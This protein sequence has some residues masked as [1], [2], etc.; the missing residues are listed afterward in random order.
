MV[1]SRPGSPEFGSRPQT[2]RRLRAVRRLCIFA[3]PLLAA[4]LVTV[5]MLAS[6]Q[7]SLIY[8]PD[9][10]PVIQPEEAG[11][12]A[13]QV[14][15]IDL[16][17]HDRLTLSGWHL[18]PDGTTAADR[19]AADR[20]L[21][22]GQPVVLYFSGN[23]GNRAY[24]GEDF[25]LF[26]GLGCHVLVFDYRGYGEN[27]G[28]PSESHLT[29]DAHSVW[30]YATRQRNVSPSRIVLFGESLGG[31][32]AVWLAAEQ[33]QASEPPRGLALRATFPS[34]PDVAA[35][36][37][38]WLPV[39]L[40]LVDRYPAVDHI[41][42]VTCPLLQIHGTQDTIVPIHLGLK[43]FDAAPPRSSSALAKRLVRLSGA[44]HNDILAVAA[45]E[46]REALRLWLRDTAETTGS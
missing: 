7:R 35:M 23:A 31:A 14:L 24:R 46:V 9:S 44:G 19:A 30:Q 2:G 8:F 34:L 37:Y 11:R 22:D 6:L 16:R 41:S 40:L 43:L 1:Q 45:S 4:G 21:A 20:Q 26:T 42:R 33:C 18:L 3:L 36:H 10:Q 17:T 27:P 38:P 5:I 15:T 13:G 25:A 29:A 28:S 39:R 12:P 32:V